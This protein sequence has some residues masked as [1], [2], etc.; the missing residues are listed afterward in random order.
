MKMFKTTIE[1]RNC[2]A[3]FDG[4]PGR[5]GFF[6]TRVVSGIHETLAK[7]NILRELA[8]ELRSRLLNDRFDPPE[9]IVK[10]VI[11]IDQS[12]AGTIAN[13]GF[14]WYREDTPHPN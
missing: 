10:E 8:E 1:G 3:N 7:E 9:I 13:A 12:E 2:W 11:E 6:T 14:T 4:Q 5:V